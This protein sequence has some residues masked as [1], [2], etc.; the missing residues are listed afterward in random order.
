M[1]IGNQAL[2]PSA[3]LMH[4]AL[5]AKVTEVLLAPSHLSTAEA[6]VD[7]IYKQAIICFLMLRR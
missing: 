2:N 3:Q 7:L 6:L 5:I 4:P 1:N